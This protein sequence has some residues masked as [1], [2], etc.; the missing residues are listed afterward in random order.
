MIVNSTF[1]ILITTKNRLNDLIFTLK[2]IE[3]ILNES[4]IECIIC[5]DGSM[6]GTFFF[7]KTTILNSN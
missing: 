4:N 1:S 7:Y 5:D 3:N 6:D 2:K